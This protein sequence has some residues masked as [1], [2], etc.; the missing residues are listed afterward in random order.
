MEKEINWGIIGCGNVTEVKSGPAFNKIKGSRLVAVMRRN[1]EMA[2]DY[3]F[4]HNVPR[5]YTD[6]SDLIND[7]EVNVIYIA[8]PP[9]SHAQYAIQSMLAG[10]PVYV[11]KPMAGNYSDCLEMIKVS[12]QTGMPLLVAYYRRM[13]PGFLKIKELLES[14]IIGKPESFT[15]R[16]F[17]PPY[18]QDLTEPKPWR[19]Q[20]EISGGGYLFDLASHQLDFLDYVLG[21]LDMVSSVAANHAKL[22]K[23]EDFVSAKFEAMNGKVK[24]T[25]LWWFT[26]PDY[27]REDYM[28]IT[29]K[30]G[31]ISFSCFGFTPVKLEADDR[32]QLF[33][34]PRPAHVQ[35]GL[36]QT[37]VEQLQEI[38]RCPSDAESASR[39]SLIL[40]K[41]TGKSIPENY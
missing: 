11:E 35:Q 27:L 5:W 16:F 9:S 4:R 7:P 21:P 8:T 29:G 19:V 38:G 28:E 15:I 32:I 3:A 1:I 23:P 40:D 37:V 24:G 17:Q 41:I 25:G 26:S 2:K 10:K 34:F 39:T 13:L 22:Y 18:P 14:G 36:I 12:R 6:A 33:D 31:K 20:P 30:N